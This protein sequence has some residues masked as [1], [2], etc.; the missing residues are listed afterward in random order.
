MTPLCS[1]VRGG[2]RGEG[3]G[4]R[5]DASAVT[6]H[7]LL[8]R[9]CGGV[10]ECP[11][12]ISISRPP[13]RRREDRTTRGVKK[14]GSATFCC[15]WTITNSDLGL[16][17]MRVNESKPHKIGAVYGINKKSIDDQIF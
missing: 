10:P 17:Y 15:G 12:A 6:Q 5:P 8:G 16:D 9:A 3:G 4:D 7:P 1:L 13:A 14:P 2:A 11:L